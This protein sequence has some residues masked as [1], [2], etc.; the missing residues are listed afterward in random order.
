MLFGTREQI[1]E[2]LAELREQGLGSTDVIDVEAPA[3]DLQSPS[4]DFELH[5]EENEKL[6]NTLHM[7]AA[8]ELPQGL[9][10]GQA[11]EVS[12]LLEF[13]HARVRRLLLA[14][15]VEEEAAQVKLAI[16]H[17]QALVEIEGLLAEYLRGIGEP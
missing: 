4:L 11:A 1:A 2:R 16:R 17:W 8:P 12:E 9:T 10:P 6:H 14:V 13:F 7:P 15:Q 5:W 3:N